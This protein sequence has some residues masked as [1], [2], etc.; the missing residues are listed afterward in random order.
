MRELE[1]KLGWKQKMNESAD[2]VTVSCARHSRWLH[3]ALLSIDKYCAGFRQV[4]II[5]PEHEVEAIKEACK[6]IKYPIVLAIGQ[7]Y[8]DGHHWQ[9][10]RK[11]HADQCSD[12]DWILISDSDWLFTKLTTP[13]SFMRDG[14]PIHLMQRYDHPEIAH[15]HAGGPVPWRGITERDCGWPVEHE[16]MRR[17]GFLYPRWFFKECQNHLEKRHGVS[18]EQWIMYRAYPI[19]PAHRRFCEFNV[20]NAYAYKMHPDKFYFLEIGKDEIP[21]CHIWQGWSYQNPE[22]PENKARI[23]AI[24]Q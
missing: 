15:G 6:D 12:A 3:Y 4:V 7:E 22:S 13:E 5:T 18:A 10:S 21:E 20:L 11:V 9:M 17:P 19:P 8:G 23:A 16:M 2:I 1:R 24:L 14:K